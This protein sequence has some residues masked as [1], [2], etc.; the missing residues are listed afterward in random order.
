MELPAARYPAG[1]GH[2]LGKRALTQDGPRASQEVTSL[3]PPTAF[4]ESDTRGDQVQEE[5]EKPY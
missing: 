5:D 2:G 3:L 4:K 1:V